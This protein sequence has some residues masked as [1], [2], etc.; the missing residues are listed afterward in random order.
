MIDRPTPLNIKSKITKKIEINFGSGSQKICSNETEELL[1]EKIEEKTKC[2]VDNSSPSTR[3][4][5]PIKGGIDDVGKDS[6]LLIVVKRPSERT[7]D[8]QSR[9]DDRHWKRPK[10][11]NKQLIDDEESPI[12]VPNVAHVFDVPSPMVSFRLPY[13]FIYLLYFLSFTYTLIF[14]C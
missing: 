9:N 8:S 11:P 12:K 7:E 5:L 2:L 10:N 14:C 13:L 6:R 3:F 4:K 1:V